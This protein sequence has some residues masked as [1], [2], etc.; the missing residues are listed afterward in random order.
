MI[1]LINL[2]D[3]QYVLYFLIVYGFMLIPFFHLFYIPKYLI[4]K[5]YFQ[6]ILSLLVFSGILALVL[7]ISNFI[8]LSILILVFSP[9]YQILLYR[10]LFSLYVNKYK[11]VPKDVTFNFKTG[12]FLDRLFA[13]GYSAI[14]QLPILILLGIVENIIRTH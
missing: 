5:K 9:I 8:S 10:Y 1:L 12:L 3:S 4:L 11:R 7:F 13:I 6:F 14:A 2:T